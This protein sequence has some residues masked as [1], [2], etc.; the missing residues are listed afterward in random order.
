MNPQYLYP[1]LA[2]SIAFFSAILDL[3]QTFSGRTLRR[4]IGWTLVYS[5][6]AGLVALLVFDLLLGIEVAIGPISAT[7]LI[8]AVVSG[9]LFR[10]LIQSKLFMLKTK[11]LDEPNYGPAATYERLSNVIKKQIS[12]SGVA[13]NVELISTYLASSVSDLRTKAVS[14]IYAHEMWTD[15][16]KKNQV[17]ALDTDLA[18]P[19]SS[20]AKKLRLAQFLQQHGGS[21]LDLVERFRK[22]V[23]SLHEQ[24]LIEIGERA[25]KLK[26]IID[27]TKQGYFRQQLHEPNVRIQTL[28]KLIVTYCADPKIIE[29]V[30]SNH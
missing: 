2:F 12:L 26:T 29:Y 7:T 22:K 21:N 16:E 13:T 1:L 28:R 18:V 20:E 11:E 17:A 15:E 10:P 9:L 27:P 24:Q 25:L 4:A 6:F 8:K 5:I 3:L 23:S 30:L 14:V 19:S